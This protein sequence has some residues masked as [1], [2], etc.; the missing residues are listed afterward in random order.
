MKN[1]S[2]FAS[3]IGPP[4]LYLFLLFLLPMGVMFIYSFRAGISGAAHD[5][6]TLANYQQFITNTHF[7]RLLWRSALIAFTIAIV[8]A[9]LAYP[10]AYYLIFRAGANRVMLMTLLI[11]PTWTS[12]LLRI[13]S[14]KLI[15]GSSGVLNS[16]LLAAGLIEKASPILIY[17]RGAVI[18]TLVY[19]WVPFVALPIFAAL[20]RID[21]NLLEA[22]ADLGCKPWQAF[23]RVTLPLSLP[24]ILA[25]F[26]FALIPTLGEF[27]TPLLVGGASGSMYGNLVQDQF[28]RALNWP[29][30][31]VMSLAMLAA[32]LLLVFILTRLGDLSDLAG[33]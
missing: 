30:G 7:L 32:V 18:V 6:F 22:A 23:L 3:L 1:R 29:M 33:I 17:S 10:L 20:E 26:F 15:L 4:S 27:V 21:K 31:S 13:F 12:Y 8:S 16:L 9:I 11:I 24:G 14:W 28:M 5:T 25:G 19:V 2:R